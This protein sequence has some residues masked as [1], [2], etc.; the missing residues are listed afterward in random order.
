VQMK[1][2]CAQAHYLLGLGCQGRGRLEEAVGHYARAVRL[3]P[4]NVEACK[5]IHDILASQG[6]HA[7]ARRWLERATSASP[8]PPEPENRPDA[9]PERQK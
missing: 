6:R 3:R 7:E 1:P 4:D 5:R 9:A 2:T 8:G